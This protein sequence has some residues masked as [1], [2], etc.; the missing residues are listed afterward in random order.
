MAG[1]TGDR[2]ATRLRR[3]LVLPVTTFRDH[4]VPSVSFY[5]LDNF[6]DFHPLPTAWIIRILQSFGKVVSN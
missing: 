3:M 4:Q 1:M 6:A 5:Q 2:Y